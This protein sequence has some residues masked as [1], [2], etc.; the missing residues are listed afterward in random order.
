MNYDRLHEFSFSPYWVSHRKE[1]DT[2]WESIK[3][4]V[5]DIII[6]VVHKID[7]HYGTVKHRYEFSSHRE[8]IVNHNVMFNPLFATIQSYEVGDKLFNIIKNEIE[9]SKPYKDE[10]IK[11]KL[12]SFLDE[13]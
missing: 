1:D 11:H 7:T 13:K 4:G 12:K 8:H 6:K 5:H 2:D 3:V 10:I 9:K